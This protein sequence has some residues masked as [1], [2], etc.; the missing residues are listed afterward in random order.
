[1]ENVLQIDIWI[2]FVTIKSVTTVALVSILTKKNVAWELYPR[3]NNVGVPIKRRG[4]AAPAPAGNPSAL[5]LRPSLTRLGYGSPSRVVALGS[6]HPWK[7]CN[8]TFRKA[9]TMIN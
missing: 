1:M 7:D 2:C 8:R 9:L 6:I 5:G 4:T 3:Q